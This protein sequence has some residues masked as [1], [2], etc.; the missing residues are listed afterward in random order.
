MKSCCEIA[1]MFQQVCRDCHPKPRQ[2]V[3]SQLEVVQGGKPAKRAG[4]AQKNECAKTRPRHEPYEVWVSRDGTWTWNVLKKWQANDDKP[5]ARWF[6]DVVTPMV[7]G[8]EMGDVYVTEI[9]QN[10]RRIR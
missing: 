1:A 6:C 3:Q 4:V 5:Y 7:P 9:K 10:A 8:G 2:R